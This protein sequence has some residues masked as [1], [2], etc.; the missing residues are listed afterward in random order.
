MKITHKVLDEGRI[1]GY[2]IENKAFIN[3]YNVK[4][5]ISFIENIKL[6]SD[7]ELRLKESLPELQ[8][9]ELVAAEYK[10]LDKQ[11]PFKRDIQ[12]KLYWWKRNWNH[13]I[14]CID[15]ARQV[16]KTTEILKFAYGNYKYVI[17]VNMSKN[18]QFES[19]MMS[20]GGGYIAMSIYCDIAN[21]IKYRDTSDTVLI[22]DEIQ[23]SSKVY[24]LL[25]TFDGDLNCDVIIT[26]SYL[27]RIANAE[28]FKPA[29]NVV[30]INMPPMSFREFLRVFNKHKLLDGI[31]LYGESD[32]SIYEE[33]FKYYETY[34]IVGGYPEVVMNYINNK[35]IEITLYNLLD[36][37]INE[38]KM[39][40]ERSIGFNIEL[41]FDNVFTEA[42]QLMCTK[43]TVSSVKLVDGILL[44]MSEDSTSKLI[45]KKNIKEVLSWL[46]NCHIIST[47]NMFV[48][49][50]VKDIEYGARIYFTDC[51]IANYLATQSNIAKSNK[52][53][54]LTETFTFN[55]LNRLCENKT[56][57]KIV[58]NKR[59]YFSI[60]G[61]YELDFIMIGKE[62][63]VFGI[64]VKTTK[65]TKRSLEFFKSDGLIDKAIY[66]GKTYGGKTEELRTIP[67]FAVGARFPYN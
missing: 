20:N 58:L 65:G 32:K 45:V 55:E 1:A 53:G 34:K 43:K 59:P 27:G 57:S 66:V 28:Y 24:N 54:M 62:N 42:I 31:S 5:N 22:V 9:S 67:I 7:G 47:S 40:F 56:S 25:R 19:I 63:E 13:K 26:G 35:D 2:I 36:M 48:D 61:Q 15:G 8:Y 41:A 23:N 16:G 38:S 33:I 52:S 4:Q 51:G 18:E 50:K 3:K 44:R 39:Y 14:I 60:K 11:N 17:Y 64:E 29:G 12:E 49:G 10:R 21:L 30:K 46:Y 37:F 6:L